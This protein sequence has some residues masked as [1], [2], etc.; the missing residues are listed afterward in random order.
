M[1]YIFRL[2]VM[3]LKF[4]EIHHDEAGS[5]DYYTLL[6]LQVLTYAAL[7]PSAHAVCGMRIVG[8]GKNRSKLLARRFL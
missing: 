6:M 8:A 3:G 7:E 1:V 5:V 2:N 4:T